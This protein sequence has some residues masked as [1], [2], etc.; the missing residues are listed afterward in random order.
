MAEDQAVKDLCPH[1]ESVLQGLT[2]GG[3]LFCPVELYRE[4]KKGSGESGVPAG[5]KEK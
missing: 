4:L 2:T 5:E 3:C 1:G